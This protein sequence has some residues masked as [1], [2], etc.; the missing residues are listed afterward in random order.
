[1][2]EKS[3]RDWQELK[4]SPPGKRFQER[5]QKQQRSGKSKWA[6]IGSFA[7]ALVA[8]AIGV[9]L[10]F[11]PGPAVVFFFLGGGMLASH[12]RAVARALDW[13]ELRLRATFQKLR[14]WW[15]SHSWRARLPVL[16]AAV[17]VVLGVG[18]AAFEIFT[19]RLSR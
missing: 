19:G 2:F 1:M 13:T 3:K 6:R 9:V 10:V 4:R 8:L 14:T 15:R 12:S 17:V 7:A 16:L 5:Y 18:A 11:I